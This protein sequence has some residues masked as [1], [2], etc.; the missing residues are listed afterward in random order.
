MPEEYLAVL[1]IEHAL[2]LF[3]LEQARNI[4]IISLHF[5]DMETEAQTSVYS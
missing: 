4:D 5:V 3:T 2:S 1:H